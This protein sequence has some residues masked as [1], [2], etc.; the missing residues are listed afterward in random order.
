MRFPFR[1]AVTLLPALFGP[2]VYAQPCSIS[3]G[4][5]V[6]ICA[7]QTTTFTL[8]AGFPNYL[9]STGATGQSLTTGAAG[10][11]WGQASYPSG[12]LVSNGTFSSGNTGFWSQFTNDPDLQGE[13]RF[14]IGTNANNH[15]PQLQ[16][17]GN[18]NFLMVNAGLPQQWWT[19]WAQG[20]AVCPSQTYTLSFRMANLANAGPASV[21]W[22][23]D[24]NNPFWQVTASG[25]QGV[26]NT[27]STTFTTGSNQYNLDLVLTVIS[28][29]AVGNDFGIDDITFSGAVNLRD[30]VQLNVTPL[31]VVDLGPDQT[32]CAGDVVTL[33]ATLPGA[34]YLWDNGSTAATRNVSSA[35]NYNVT[36][37]A[38]GC[39]NS[40]AVN[41]NYTPLPVVNLGPDVTLCAGDQVVLNAA[42]AG[43][44]YLWDNGSTNATRS[45]STAGTYSVAI[46][47][48]GCVG[49]DAVNVSVTPLPVVDLGPDVA[50][51]T[52]D[53]LV[54][55]ATT[56][57][58]SYLWDDASTGA[59]RPVSSAG[60]Y[61]VNVTVNGCTDSDLIDVLVNP[62]P[63]FSLGPDVTLC[64]GDQVILDATTAGATYVWDDGS[65]SA[66]RS[67]SAAGTY[68]VDVTV[69]GC[70]SSDAV[71]VLV[72][73][74]PVV[75]LGLDVTIC[76]GGQTVLD[77]TTLGASYLWDNGSTSAT[78]AVTAAGT[79]SVTVTVNGCTATDA[80]DV[81]VNPLPVIDLGPD[82]TICP[83]VQTTLDATTPGATY[84]W[85]GGSTAAMLNVSSA[86]NYSVDVT[87]NGCTTTDDVDIAVSNAIVV[88]LGPDIALC[89]GDQVIL[90]ATT[91][92]ATYLWDNGTT[93]A[94]RAVNATGTYSVTVTSGGCSGSDAIDVQVTPLP[95]VDLGSDQTICAGSQTILDATTAGATYL[96]DN[97]STGATRT[98]NTAGT[99]SV[100]VTTAGC[101]NS[102]AVDVALTPLPVV[103][104]GPDVSLC[105][106]DQVILDATTAGATYVWDNG[107]TSATRTVSTTGTYDVTVTV[108][109]CSAGDAIDVTV[110]P[111]PVVDL[112]PDV[113]IC[114]GDQVVLDATT[115]GATYLWD[116]GSTGATRAVSSAGTFNV[117]VTVNGCTATDAVDVS[118]NPLP[119]IDLG[120]DQ[121][122]CPG[123]QTTLD[124]TTPGATYLWT[125]GGT[126][127]TL[128]VSSAGNYSVDVTVNGCTT[129]DD[130]DVAVFN[131]IVV[132]IGP[133]VSICAGDQLI[134]DATAPSATYLWD[135][136]TTGA[137][138]TVNATGTYSVTVTSG[139][140]SGSDAIDVQVTP[141]PVVD[142]GPDQTICAG[143][144]SILDATTAGATYLWDN[145]S[146]GATRTVNTAGTF[147]VTVT[148][149][150][151]S[152]TDAVDVALTPLPVLSLGPD[153]SLCAGDQVILDATTAGATYVWDN[154]STA[155][156]RAVS[157]SGTYDVTVTVA[158][159]SANDAIDVN[160]VP[161]PVVD[162][163]PDVTICAG[164]QTLIDATTPGAAYLWQDGSTGA[165]YT[166]SMAGPYSVTVTV[167]ACTNSDAL[168]L[169][170]TPLPLVDLGPDVAVC[171]GDQITLDVTTINAT[172]LWQDGSTGATYTAASTGNYA[173][174]VTSNGC[175]ASD[176]MDLT[177]NSAP[178]VDLGP[179]LSLC[180]GDDVI[181][182]AT[183]AGATYL[184]QDGSNSPTFLANGAGPYSVTVTTGS[185]SGSDQVQITALVAPVFSL[186][187][188]STLCPGETLLLDIP[189]ANV[190]V[191]WQDGSTAN[192]FLVNS[193][194]PYSATVTNADGCS[195]T[196]AVQIAYASTSAID[197]GNDTTLCAGQN[198]LL[199]AFLPGATYLWSTGATSSSISVNS[200][201]PV[202]VIVTQGACSVSD[203]IDVQVVA[204][205]TVQ[206]GNDTTLCAG[207][208]LMLDATTV[209][210]TYLWQDGSTG[211]TFQVQQ[212]GTFSVTLTNAQQCSGT[213]AVLV[214][215]AVPGAINLGPDLTLCAGP[216]VALDATLP[217]ATYLWSTGATSASI[218]A[219]STDTYWVEAAQ[220]NCTLTDTVDLTFL[221]VPTADLGPDLTLCSGDQA[222][223]DVAWPNATYLWS[224]GTIAAQFTASSSGPVW[225][226]VS[227]GVCSASDTLGVQVNPLPTVDL[228][229]D[230]SICPGEELLLDATEPGA[231][232]L[233]QDGSTSATFLA[234]A[235][236]PYAVT[237]DLNGCTAT[238]AMSLSLL[239]APMI[240]LG[241]DTSVCDGVP[242]LLDPGASNATL[243]WSDGTTLPT[244]TVSSSDTYW[245]QATANGCTTN[246]TITV[247][248]V[249]LG[250]LDLGPDTA[251][252]PG[253][254]ILLN[255]TVPGASIIWQNG[256]TAPT[257]TVSAAGTWSATAL[258]NGCSVQ[259][260]IVIDLVVLPADP[261]GPDAF[262][263]PGDSLLLSVPA[264]STDV[265]WSDASTLYDLLVTGPGNYSVSASISGCAFT[266][267][268]TLSAAPAP[269][270][271]LGPDIS[272]CE[273][274]RV[275][276]SANSPLEVV[277]ST[278]STSE[279][280]IVDTPGIYW[281]AVDGGCAIAIDT[282]LVLL[283]ECGP[284]IHVP[285]AFTPDGDGI[286]DL[287]VPSVEGVLQNYALD[288]FDRWGERIFS[289]T[290]PNQT[291]DGTHGGSPVP[292]GVYSWTLTYK[293]RNRDG[294]QQDR[295]IGHV[296]LL[297]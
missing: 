143:S 221:P 165:T 107:S 119:V 225:V 61:S 142:L 110:V 230:A 45:V 278:G 65:T 19:V 139:G 146:T 223:L 58:A 145:G 172:Y 207:E 161:I 202:D 49:T 71:D 51:C 203:A 131:A 2:V 252:C 28:N 224:D 254:S 5:D 17:T 113:A 274:E 236:G 292:D 114:A 27:Y 234:D 256:S 268:V 147:S 270:A 77:A 289:S 137:T 56:P 193:G 13:G 14:W 1:I 196:D 284:Y 121:T 88:D 48:N 264:Q 106:G 86:G 26:W 123:V 87:V 198:I 156:T 279:D 200:A 160:V 90:D 29:W 63:V 177:V 249:N 150:G 22:I 134:L 184:W 140:C 266:D 96:W 148:T 91:P 135:N 283:A 191:L 209:G 21:E 227:L 84:L 70:S 89:A 174:T 116:N 38:N 218:N 192:S 168:T 238:D 50:L 255:A 190:S 232:Y 83:G 85:T 120:P 12:N 267:A 214:S 95:V 158:G 176:A 64:A 54:L 212:A 44:T 16:G 175:S 66:T 41:I 171:T 242:L 109:G 185:C 138:R 244:L 170:T 82:Q 239:N 31:P 295:L 277:W 40:D 122:I 287:F 25:G 186:G 69:N 33:D 80:V 92:S 297:R 125:G 215:Y 78:R 179:D 285:N 34:T 141:L 235:S 240:E 222:V 290:V 15:H 211:A 180:P 81:S 231:T 251:L 265:L 97:G 245:L 76:A 243:L 57:G 127:A 53:Q 3:L 35:G 151:C 104:L 10:T 42:T 233:W 6:T 263:C 59:T 258:L 20:V 43:A 132:D 204:S 157:S 112:G 271:D 167:G 7:G 164:D 280:I 102:D 130:V 129:T 149:A 118:V 30:T 126:A 296:T 37:T 199:D 24:W 272:L 248:F 208:I 250:N 219:T 293:A 75:D 46:T 217:G 154:G 68:S 194:G 226:A 155:A 178:V 260:A 47:V 99:F 275:V 128:N 205:P 144:Q 39:S 281:V 115:P 111:L 276:L 259:D 52:G 181:L 241:T 133:D 117:D 67:V 206:L 286:N 201:G 247:A 269:G 100:T 98:V 93:G 237:V 159:C 197:L 261:L 195:S 229:P 294:V 182:D 9:W 220:G 282:I 62:L 173:V 124:A 153:V 94:T 188:D 73:P 163:G 166:A 4:N 18:G 183:L 105:A 79:Y 288:I 246:D 216:A 189:L 213:D 60:T 8:P 101:S 228:G 187:N 23:A 273:G 152:N 108:A 262:L 162:L 55:D 210:C 72:N 74:L 11:Y 136:G 36:V 257:Q 32:V 291:W 253:T 169:W 103:S